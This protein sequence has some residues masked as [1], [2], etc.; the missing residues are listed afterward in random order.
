MARAIDVN[1]I[2]TNGLSNKMQPNKANKVLY[3]LLIYR[4]YVTAKSAL[5]AVH[6][7]VTNTRQTTLVIEVV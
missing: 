1:Y 4:T 3:W 7:Y 6:T 2:R 5:P